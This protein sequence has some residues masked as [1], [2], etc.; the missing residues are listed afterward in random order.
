MEG[1]RRPREGLL[2]EFLEAARRTT[3]R[4]Q[5]GH[6][7]LYEWLWDNAGDLDWEL[8]PPRRPNWNALAAKCA[9]AGLTDGRG[10]A[11]TGERVRKTWWKVRQ[12][13]DAMAQGPL[14]RKPRGRRPAG[15]APVAP[16]QVSAP[17]PAQR[18]VPPAVQ[19]VVQESDK[20]EPFEER[21]RTFGFATPRR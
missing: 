6:S 16:G 11:P 9:E 18:E 12:Q 5:G 1:S 13:R 8:S 10:Q 3:D 17:A 7:P 14:P 2:E 20:A 4:P 15:A 21:R 19:A